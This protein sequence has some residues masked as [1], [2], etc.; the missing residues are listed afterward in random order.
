[1]T[2]VSPEDAHLLQERKWSALATRKRSVVYACAGGGAGYLQILLHCKILGNVAGLEIDHK[3]H[4]GT[5]NRRSNLRHATASQNLGNSRHAHGFAGYR[6]VSLEKR[7]GRWRAD[8]SEK[9]LGYFD[10]PE[11]AARAY[12]AAAIERFGEFATLNFPVEL[13]EARHG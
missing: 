4:D 2:F 1:V 12:D 10:T 5:N 3:D 13:R 7:T 6:G 8:I 11:A 9:Y